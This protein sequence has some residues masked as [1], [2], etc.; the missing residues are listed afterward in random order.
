M[1]NRSLR[2]GL[3]ASVVTGALLLGGLV[4]APSALANPPDNLT[5][6]GNQTLV[7]I[8]EKVCQPNPNRP[9]LV[10]KRAC[11]QNPAGKVHCRHFEHCPP[12]SP[13]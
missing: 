6:P 4:A 5:C 9:P 12:R 13:S 10:V 8:D 2:I 1:P 3:R 11:C 7:R